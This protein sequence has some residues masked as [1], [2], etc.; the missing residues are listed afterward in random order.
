MLPDYMLQEPDTQ[1]QPTIE[2]LS[3]IMSL[4]YVD[5]MGVFFDYWATYPKMN[6]E[7][8][9]DKIIDDHLK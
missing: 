3:M 4:S 7:Q 2:E 6:Q 5:M 1:E 8:V 9:I